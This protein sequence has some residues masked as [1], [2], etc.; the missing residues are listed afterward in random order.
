MSAMPTSQPHDMQSL[1]AAL[2]ALPA[3]VLVVAF[4]IHST[5]VS[6]HIWRNPLAARVRA[7]G[8]VTVGIC[9][10]KGAEDARLEADYTAIIAER[11]LS[12]L[13]RVNVVIISDMDGGN[14]I[15]PPTAKV[16][17]CIHAFSAFHDPAL[18][19]HVF[20]SSR[21]D[22]WLMPFPLSES[23]KN[24]IRALWTGFTSPDAACRKGRHFHLIPVGYPG[25]AVLAQ[26]LRA[27]AR[28]P[29][30][31]V[32]APVGRHSYPDCGGNRLKCHG[33]RLVRSLLGAFPDLRVIFRPYKTDLESD[34]V[35]E[36][37]ATFAGEPRFVPDT[38]PGREFA[39]AH[40]ALLVTDLSHIAQTFAFSTLR[41]ALY[42]HPWLKRKQR[43]TS[44]LG[45]F[46][47]YSYTGLVQAARLCL[48]NTREWQQ[49]IRTER[50]RLTMPFDTAL[51]DIAGFLREFYEDAPRAEWLTIER[52]DALVQRE[53][54]LLARLLDQPHD[55]LPNLAA[56]ALMCNNPQSPLLTAFALHAGR[57]HIPKEVLYF[58][59]AIERAAGTLL[60]RTFACRHY[61]DV[62]AEDVR[63]LYSLA[64]LEMFK[65]NDADGVAFVEEL[66]NAFNVLCPEADTEDGT[67]V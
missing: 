20:E 35:K 53:T 9:T 63:T 23:D 56:A 29:D 64:L 16:L 55:V 18:S 40:G 27:H 44:W 45:G 54:A 51:D 52:D 12:P 19:W 30:A 14:A 38:H 15:Y 61:E 49:R 32:Y 37:C 36:I 31:I 13:T 43:R 34:E 58:Q 17:G 21:L 28:E 2:A 60:G 8:H 26:G 57:K 11:D 25:M 6:P 33:V 39:F 66:L 50:S 41:P 62:D 59:P 24:A 47:A 5:N 46:T 4:Y 65:K 1:R 48:E 7:A 3:D 22:G 67:G 10:P 42:F